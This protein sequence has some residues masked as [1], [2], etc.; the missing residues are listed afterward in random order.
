MAELQDLLKGAETFGAAF[1]ALIDK[2]LFVQP[3]PDPPRFTILE[4]K[5]DYFIALWKGNTKEAEFFAQ[6]DM[7]KV[8][9]LAG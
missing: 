5:S 6:Y 9:T 4:T 3:L 8:F 1:G 7:K 2:T